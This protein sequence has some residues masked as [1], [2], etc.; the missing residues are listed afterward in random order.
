MQFSLQ[1]FQSTIL[2]TDQTA[3]PLHIR[4][5]GFDVL[6]VL[7]LSDS[8]DESRRTLL[9]SPG[10]RRRGQR[11]RAASPGAGELRPTSELPLQTPSQLCSQ[12]QW[13]KHLCP[14]MT[15]VMVGDQ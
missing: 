10:L 4:K 5:L 11:E 7:P 13:H 12:P 6:V 9:V 1:L 8:Q 14:L 15:E 3:K 2:V